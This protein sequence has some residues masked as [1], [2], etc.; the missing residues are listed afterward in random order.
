MR[1]LG[2]ME[3]LVILGERNRDGILNS[4]KSE[5]GRSVCFPV[6]TLHVVINETALLSAQTKITLPSQEL[7]HLVARCSVD[8]L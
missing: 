8:N 4:R 3:T 5:A 1:G 7:A 6:A 2:D